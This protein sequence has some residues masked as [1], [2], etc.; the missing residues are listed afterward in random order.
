MSDSSASEEPTKTMPSTA[1][2]PTEFQK[3]CL[4][5]LSGGRALTIGEIA[6][7][8][9]GMKYK[10]AVAS[11]MRAL[12]RNGQTGPESSVWVHRLPPRDQW[13]SEFWC[14]GRMG[15]D[16]VATPAVPPQD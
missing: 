12:R 8:V 14:L 4:R 10:A 13:C 7:R 11:A 9:G 6:H 16:F 15:R 2:E 3:K 1:G 5:A